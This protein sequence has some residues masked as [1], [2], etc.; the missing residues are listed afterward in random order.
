MYLYFKYF[1]I[2]ANESLQFTITCL[3]QR[4]QINVKQ[5]CLIKKG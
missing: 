1:I 2:F 5:T 3:N 4:F